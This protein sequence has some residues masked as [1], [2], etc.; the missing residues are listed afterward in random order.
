MVV[1]DGVFARVVFNQ[2]D[3][4][5]T[6]KGFWV[7]KGYK[8]DIPGSYTFMINDYTQSDFLEFVCGGEHI[9]LKINDPRDLVNCNCPCCVIY[10]HITVQIPAVKPNCA[11]E[12]DSTEDSGGNILP[13]TLK[14]VRTHM[15][16]E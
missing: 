15:L 14:M 8:W 10:I 13:L 7:A 3:E 9:G 12:A 2:G 11:L 6:I 5:C 1:T 4:L 16:R